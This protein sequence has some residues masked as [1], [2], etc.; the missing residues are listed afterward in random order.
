M[1]WSIGLTYEALSLCRWVDDHLVHVLSP[2]IYRNTSEALESFEY[3]TSHG[4]IFWKLYFKNTNLG[5]NEQSHEYSLDWE[6]YISYVLCS[7][8]P[9]IYYMAFLEMG[10]LNRVFRCFSDQVLLWYWN[11]SGQNSIKS[12]K[13]KKKN[14]RYWYGAE[15][16]PCDFEKVT[17]LSFCNPILLMVIRTSCLWGYSFILQIRYR[18]MQQILSTI[19]TMK[20]MN[21]GIERNC[22]P[23][24]NALNAHSKYFTFRFFNVSKTYERHNKY[25]MH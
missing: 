11:P 23:G 20:S 13:K 15:H 7:S 5:F 19:I 25:W 17:L 9:D 22:N 14:L 16:A 10:H 6:C 21:T 8:A 2:N 24:W 12:D 18:G 4:K 3:I 1:D